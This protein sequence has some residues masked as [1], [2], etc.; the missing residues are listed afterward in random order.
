MTS[1]IGPYLMLYPNK[2][3]PLAYRIQCKAL[4]E[5]KYFFFKQYGGR[6]NAYKEASLSVDKL[7]YRLRAKRLREE[8]PINTLFNEDGTIKGLTTY[9]L[10]KTGHLSVVIKAKDNGRTKV[11]A[12]RSLKT[13][14]LVDSVDELFRAKLNYTGLAMTPELVIEYKAGRAIFLKQTSVKAGKLG[15]TLK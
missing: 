9:F 11:I 14:K 10:Q 4:K 1:E 3:K 13:N 7:I 2:M 15:L 5:N 8:L 12:E 6:E